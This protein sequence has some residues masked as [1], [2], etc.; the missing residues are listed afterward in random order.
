MIV[1]EEINE[2]FEFVGK[3]K[4][5]NNGRQSLLESGS[6]GFTEIMTS[7]SNLVSEALPL[8]AYGVSLNNETVN[9]IQSGLWVEFIYSDVYE[10][11]GLPFERLLIKV[12]ICYQGFNLIRYTSRYGYDG[13][14]FYLNLKSGDMSDF[15]NI[16]L[17]I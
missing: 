13:R 1:L 9:A 12:E 8:P 7:W 15:Y 16:L 17:N 2:A 3:V 5:I 14:C 4:V 6:T 11:Y 10:C